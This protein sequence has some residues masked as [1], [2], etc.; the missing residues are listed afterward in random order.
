MHGLWRPL[1]VIDTER[2]KDYWFVCNK[3]LGSKAPDDALTER[4]LQA[5]KE[6]PRKDYA[7]YKVTEHESPFAGTANPTD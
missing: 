2:G 4:T 7:N 5:C 1:Q 3:W 6:D